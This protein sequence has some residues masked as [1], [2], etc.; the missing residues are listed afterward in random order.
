MSTSTRGLRRQEGR[1]K[2]DG[3]T[4]FTADLE[5]PGL[6]HVQLVLSHYPSARIRSCDVAAACAVPGVVAVVTG[7]DLL[8]VEAAGPDKP[9]AVDRVFFAGQPVVAVIAESESAATDAAALVEVDYEPLPAVANPEQAMRDG[10]PEVLEAGAE[11]SEGDASMHGAATDSESE[12]QER[13]RNVSSVASYKRGDIE[14][15]LAAA[16]V[17]IKATYRIAGVHHSF[18]ETHVSMVRPE[19]GGG[20][21]IWAPTQG[22]FVVRDE[23]AKVLDVAPHEVRVIS[24]P[25][26]GGF[27]G[28]V[29]LLET[30]LVLLARKVRRPL[31][32]A[33][34]RQQEFQLGRPAPAAKFDI[35]LGAKRDGTL[36]ALHARYQYDNGATGGWHAGITGSFLGGT[37]RIP[38][39]DLKGYEVATNKTPTDAYRAP[40]GPQAYFAL[41]SAMDELAIE[42]SMDPIELRLHN[43]SREGDLNADEEP[44]P[45]IAMVECLEA[46]RRHPLYT[47]PVGL[48]EGVGIALA[49]WG[50]ARSPGAA[51]CRVEPDGTV[52][53]LI[54]SPDISGSATGLAMIAAEAFGVPAEKVRVDIGDTSFA[55]QG[56]MAAGSQVTY[57]LGGAVYEAALE[58]RRQL[59]EIAT[60]ELEAAPED[61]DIADGRVT[62]KGVPE[63]FVEITKL[64]ALSTEFM[65]RHRPI[66]ATGRSAVQSAS[67]SFTVHIARVRTD[68]E[69][70]AFQLTGYAAIQDVGR[71]I[72]PPE[73]RGQ[74]HGGAAQSLGRAL[75]EALVYDAEGQLRSGSF[76]DY[77]LPTADQ[78]P[79]ID[80]ELIEVPSPVGPLGAKGV[81]EPP[82][83]P[84][85]GALTNALARATGI[86]VRN[87]P[88]DRSALVK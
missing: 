82:A 3:S 5:L 72:N 58:A 48:G 24:M 10:A 50:G 76:L 60:E 79:A 75:G 8:E 62:V 69:T 23:I 56:P 54:G 65:G 40:G 61:L 14:A 80:I 52:S 16:D 31:R 87:V 13:P 55:P 38:N 67:P 28:K 34:T 73:V 2:V 32:L 81:G 49:S 68:P 21:T 36:T 78:L 33:L 17:V 15:G 84:G 41:E 63:R 6:L 42:L 85:P 29:T 7:P 44:W 71:A 83:I 46:A 86:R 74:M 18:I 53:I 45:R 26:G 77:E 11:G 12:P 64:V 27:G 43:A 59:L 4:R 47:A 88:V 57:S 35:E 1:G 70:G 25:V 66:N 30:L 39:F 19:P 22:P 37:Y 9:L 51:G 20:V